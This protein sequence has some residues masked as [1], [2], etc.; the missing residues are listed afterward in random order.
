M[1][2]HEE[3]PFHLRNTFI[4]T[5]FAYTIYLVFGTR[6]LVIVRFGAVRSFDPSFGAKAVGIF[7]VN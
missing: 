2:K 3:S 6:V 5:F 1:A 4:L 7:S